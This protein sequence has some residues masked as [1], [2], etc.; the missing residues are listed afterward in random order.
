[1]TT[2]SMIDVL[3][4]HAAERSGRLMCSFS[5]EGTESPV[6]WSYQD[7][8]EHARRIAGWLQEHDM[9]ERPVLLAFP[10]GIDF[11]AAFL[12]CLYAKS[13]AVPTPPPRRNPAGDRFLSIY[14]NCQ[15]A[16]VLT[17][18]DVIERIPMIAKKN[19][20]VAD[21]PWH[22]PMEFETHWAEAWSQPDANEETIAFVQY[23]SGSTGD[24]RG[25]VV[26]HGNLLHNQEL[27]RKTFGQTEDMVMV[28]WLPMHHDMGLVGTLLHPLTYGGSVHLMS[29]VSF[30]QSPL[31]WLKLMSDV[32]ATI[33]TAP[34][35]AY[36][37]CINRVSS[38]DQQDL[39]LSSLQTLLNG[40]EPVRASTL[41][42]FSEKFSVNGFRERVFCPCYG[43]AETTL[44]VSGV[45]RDDEPLDELIVNADHQTSGSQA[46][47][48]QVATD[49]PAELVH[50]GRP[51]P[52]VDVRIVDPVSLQECSDTEI[53]EV[54]VA[55]RS[56]ARGY[57]EHP[58][59]TENTFN[60]KLKTTQIAEEETSYL[61]TGD[62]GLRRDGRL[63]IAGR[64]KDV[65]ILNGVNYYPHDLEAT[66]SAAHDGLIDGRAVAFGFELNGAEEVGLVLESSRELLSQADDSNVLN[67]ILSAVQQT[68]EIAVATVALVR[69]GTVP[70]TSSGKV[71]RQLTKERFLRGE[72]KLAASW[73]RPSATDPR[74]SQS[75]STQPNNQSFAAESTKDVIELQD[76]MQFQLSQLLGIKSIQVDIHEPFA[77]FGLKS[78]HAVQFCS[79]VSDHLQRKVEP[80]LAYD[81]PSISTLAKH[82]LTSE[83]TTPDGRTQLTR[84]RATRNEP[85]AIIGMGCRFPGADNPEEFWKLLARGDRVLS[86][87][88]T[89][90]WNN[91]QPPLGESCHQGGLPPK[92]GFL[93]Q[94][95]QFDPLFF[96]INPREAA[97]MDPQQRLALEVCWEALEHAGINP[98]E[99][100][101]SRTGVF[102]GL[103]NNDYLQLQTRF[104]SD[105]TGYNATGSS[106]AMAA[107]RISYTLSLRGPS[108]AVDTAC[109][110]SLVAVHYACESLRHGESDLALCGGVNL[111]AAP[112]ATNSLA[113][114]GM[115]SESGES[116]AFSDE[117]DGYIRGEGC[118][119]VLVKRL[120]DAIRDNDSIVAV[121]S[122]TA[123]NHDGRSNGLTAPSGIAQQQVIRDALESA[124]VKPSQ[125]DYLE[126]HGTGTT[127]GDQIELHALQQVFGSDR[128]SDQSLQVGSVKSNFGHLEA[129]AGIAGLIK[130]C[131]AMNHC[132]IPAHV[133]PGPQSQFLSE[134]LALQVPTKLTTWSKSEHPRLAGIS[135]F[136]FGGTN[137]HCVIQQAPTHPPQ[138]TV[139]SD[140]ELVVLTAK[141]QSALKNLAQ[142]FAEQLPDASLAT[143]AFTAN[144]SRSVFN[145]RLAILAKDR[146][147]LL[148]KLNSAG[149]AL[150]NNQLHEDFWLTST[151]KPAKIVWSFGNQGPQSFDLFQELQVRSVDF[152]N[153]WMQLQSELYSRSNI[154]LA[155]L[156]SPNSSS[157]TYD[158]S[159]LCTLCSQWLL[160]E[161]FKRLA[162]PCNLIQVE[163]QGIFAAAV[164]SGALSL[165]T[166]LD[167]LLDRTE[168]ANIKLQDHTVELGFRENSSAGQ[169]PLS[170]DGLHSALSNELNRE[171]HAEEVS[172]DSGFTVG[173]HPNPPERIDRFHGLGQMSLS[174]FPS[175]LK[176]LAKLF[177]E[178]IDVTWRTIYPH[179]SARTQLPTYPFERQTYWLSSRSTEPTAIHVL[180]TEWLHSLLHQ[181]I[182]LATGD[183][184]FQSDLSKVSYLQDHRVNGSAIVPMA[185]ILEMAC[186]AGRRVANSVLVVE[187]LTVYSPV[188][189]KANHPCI[190][191]LLLKPE[192]SRWFGSLSEQTQTGWIE[193]ATFSLSTTHVKKDV[194]CQ[195]PAAL[196]RP[197]SNGVSI[198]KHYDRLRQHGLQ[199]G[200]EFQRVKYLFRDTVNS[201]AVVV[202]PSASHSISTCIHPATLDSCLQTIVAAIPDS[203]QRTLLPTAVERFEFLR[204]ID[205]LAEVVC[206]VDSACPDE[207]SGYV[208]N[209]RVLDLQGNLIARLTGL[210]LEPTEHNQNLDVGYYQAIWQTR[211]RTQ[212][213][214]P[215]F[216]PS[217]HQLCSKLRENYLAEY[218]V[219]TVDDHLMLLDQL[220]TATS[221]CVAQILKAIGLDFS[222]SEFFTFESAVSHCSVV[223]SR[224]QLFRRLLQIATEDGLLEEYDKGYRVA[225]P[226]EEWPD[227]N[228]PD[229]SATEVALF[230]RCVAQLPDLLTTEIDP[231]PIL[232][233][234]DSVLASASDLYH[235]S[236]GSSALNHL[237]ANLASTVESR[238]PAGRGLS[239]LEVGAGTGAT[240]RQV[241][242]ELNGTRVRYTFT[243]VS[244][245]F[246]ASAKDAFVSDEIDS[247][248]ILD[249]EAPPAEQGFELHSFDLVIAANVLHATNDLE[250]SLQHVR[251]LLRPNGMLVLVEGTRRVR[252]L[253]LIFGMTD[254]WWSFQDHS[255]RDE[256]PMISWTQ[257]QSV[258]DKTGFKNCT[259]VQ[260]QSDQCQF[261]ADNSMFIAQASDSACDIEQAS[262]DWIVFGC[263]SLSTKI[264]HELNH[265]HL[266]SVLQDWPN[267][268][269]ALSDLQRLGSDFDNQ[270]ASSCKNSYVI[271]C[272]VLDAQDTHIAENTLA[273]LDDLRAL[274]QEIA[275][276]HDTSKLNPCV[277]F[278][279]QNSQ[280]P[281]DSTDCISVQQAAWHG[282]ARTLSLEL[283]DWRVQC[284]DIKPAE[285]DD[286]IDACVDELLN[287]SN[288][289]EV[290]FREAN[291]Y[292]RRLTA[293]DAA[294][295]TSKSSHVLRVE[296]RGTLEGLRL[297]SHPIEELE[298]DEILVKVVSSGLNFRD[299]LNTL[300]LY[301]GQPPLGAE[302]TG[303]V[304]AIGRDV[305]EFEPGDRVAVI[306]PDTICDQV[307]VKS[308]LATHI[309]KNISLEDAASIP[310]AFLT[311]AYALWDLANLR[312]NDRLLV[313]SAAGGVG[314]AAVQLGQLAG[315]E[316]Y[317]TASVG[318]Q[319]FLR[320][321]MSIDRV[322]N[323]RDHAF[324]KELCSTSHKA[325][326]DVLLN[327]LSEEFI[328]DNLSVI[329]LGG[330]YV[331][332]SMTSPESQSYIRNTRPD[333]CYH[334]VNL[335][336]YL[337]DNPGEIRERLS[338]L[339]DKFEHGELRPLPIRRFPLT[340]FREAFRFLQSAKNIGKVVLTTQMSSNQ[341]G[342]IEQSHSTPIKISNE[343]CY[344]ITGGL[345]G[346]GLETA[347]FLSRQGASNIVLLGRSDPTTEHEYKLQRI[348]SR[349]TRVNTF[350]CDVSN[351]QE[352]STT[353]NL[354]RSTIAEIRG[355]I[356]SAGA[357]SDRRFADHDIESFRTVFHPKVFGA[358]NL[359]QATRDDRLDFFVLYSSIAGHLGSPG[360]INHSAANTFLDGLASH[361][362][363]LGLPA[364]S[365]AWG[366]WAQVGAAV[367]DGRFQQEKAPFLELITP[368]E[369]ADAIE[370]TLRLQRSQL[371]IMKFNPQKLSP[372]LQQHPL[373]ELLVNEPSVVS[374]DVSEDLIST[375]RDLPANEVLPFVRKFLRQRIAYALSIDN[376]MQVGDEVAFFDLG[377]D[378]LTTLEL[379]EEL[380]AAWAVSL[381]SSLFFDYPNLR[382][383]SKHMSNLVSTHRDTENS[384]I[385]HVCESTSTYE[386]D[387]D[388]QGPEFDEENFDED[389]EQKLMDIASEL[390]QWDDA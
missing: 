385:D 204:P 81:Y 88:P 180:A 194:P 339:F 355:V 388:G 150:Q 169:E 373:F 208:T 70:I 119:M 212:E 370:E 130:A 134:Q 268:S 329:K 322:F 143:I 300:G 367:R 113:Q 296:K 185:G 263:D 128:C 293:M 138:Q 181:H 165:A 340:Q 127:L 8:D 372:Q 108:L 129:A 144:T 333:I 183:S 10:P 48:I 280:M 118:G 192:G 67:D 295:S 65:I 53:G 386:I 36:E 259:I 86:E 83:T 188:V 247:F 170:V 55:S 381:P 366:P 158:L 106:L 290:V 176:V 126:A 52:E 269:T 283:P 37:L 356:H 152:Q 205:S 270:K 274:V 122:G 237:V 145:Q 360:Q 245:H 95:D 69:P 229:S 242:K 309:P 28:G 140:G 1:M 94:I 111:I 163:G 299:V 198:Q 324:A 390:S 202:N 318:K 305:D 308:K 277:V 222:V 101:D 357:L 359:H 172:R 224:K 321:E 154:Q 38:E 112:M 346:L 325:S 297:E 39:D 233:P 328:D 320:E 27:I 117:V 238:L 24:P 157:S 336:D 294:A 230:R 254:G 92:G 72:F 66:A 148:S 276:E 345:G 58:E 227:T 334:H 73:K 105:V 184:V 142:R 35:F 223:N 71:Q 175:L 32:R 317:A 258:F 347:D 232:F 257:W 311:A 210:R 343:G 292:V 266:N 182:D 62:L 141:T 384:E 168:L 42:K 364:I 199:Y 220:E 23:T 98:H 362:R 271:V 349:R 285:G 246:L 137:A 124:Q 374:T 115:L 162:V 337:Q 46:E 275:K 6:R 279:T 104:N 56:V 327:T 120:S 25:V 326:V 121:I 243:D 215:Q 298:P 225:V 34:N 159:R 89:D 173:C 51:L 21:L 33:S 316:I 49:C 22:V 178:G 2:Q 304:V 196:T 15:P 31:R 302:C 319:D 40:A 344:V 123:I 234:T 307:K 335:A 139:Q 179:N 341:N 216:V 201:W 195:I 18:K 116:A 330:R 174:D 68:W 171:N 260:P 146:N 350:A 363:S 248:D 256:H 314:L 47:G 382:S 149:H 19:P 7:V 166:A 125:I 26:D 9:S 303:I 76:W 167:L 3:R 387:F 378:S 354:V 102:L 231:L 289:P 241:L 164:V 30:V 301:P 358:W 249:L 226:V 203:V 132:E 135:S 312:P 29:P 369:G 96:G 97:L 331:D 282:F 255:L 250:R 278:V 147:D 79:L 252:W 74:S 161:F 361:R 206:S 264:S 376:E 377:L 190:V 91:W 244:P 214:P 41:R 59:A 186:V 84:S 262:S 286:A 93:D 133:S 287:S 110:S 211:L 16:A 43:M 75:E 191:Q 236:V 251:Q 209:L 82:L 136:G 114:A 13:I 379:K 61:R 200:P 228:L 306:A 44:L 380:Q 213:L 63:Y 155:D 57:W 153:I 265:R 291:R 219:A 156:L 267:N 131:L 12:G 20:F 45:C 103:S 218:D 375:L 272:P 85:I 351:F 50:C 78:V 177:V 389:T 99:L 310:I 352:L 353:L 240:T 17:S 332:V 281:C 109:S 160:S 64:L 90:R 87:Y 342:E 261:Q 323:S 11:V 54:W 239:I 207:S 197:M 315:A 14:R 193:R 189:I 107:N 313:H 235:H 60:A 383:L 80:V 187:D 348:R 284:I 4:R 288:E 221:A 77:R 371:A 365:I 368:T 100:K 217:S 5:T 273:T 253:D 151:T 338:E